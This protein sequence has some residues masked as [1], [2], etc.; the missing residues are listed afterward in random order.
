MKRTSTL[1]VLVISALALVGV[2]AVP[3][4]SAAKFVAENGHINIASSSAT[5]QIAFNG[6]TYECSG[7]IVEGSAEGQQVSGG[8]YASSSL[9]SSSIGKPNCV[10]SSMNWNGCQLTFHAPTGGTVQGTVDIGP[11]GCGPVVFK[12]GS[13]ERTISAQS[14][15][16]ATYESAG[17][18]T[19]RTVK[20]A[21]LTSTL[22]YT[23]GEGC[24]TKGSF[25]NGAWSA[26]L[27]LGAT[28][29]N[30][31][32][33]GLRVAVLPVGVYVAGAQPRF[34][35]EE[36][37]TDLVGQISKEHIFTLKEGVGSF[38]LNCGSASLNSALA[39]ASTSLDVG[40]GYTSCAK[41]LSQPVKV[42]MNSCSY[43]FQVV[44]ASPYSGT[45]KVGCTVPGDAIEFVVAPE[46]PLCIY[47]LPAQT[48]GTA[49]YTTVDSL[50]ERR[51]SAEVTGTG[52]T[53]N[54]TYNG[55][56]CPVGSTTGGFS[57]GF[58]LGGVE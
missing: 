19:G 12:Q 39:S 34:E 47:Q 50:N 10:S 6:P 16:G 32:A 58:S 3:S 25:S 42:N 51:I 27:T 48:L 15:I 36:Y 33:V 37:S 11:P 40:A 7:P 35:A 52:L 21:I 24:G 31:K 45:A 28:D 2:I 38:S 18:G 20:V 13:C 43:L 46:K 26:K 30:G 29:S 17:T 22:K 9:S 23:N 56:V 44:S 57:G 14:G 1:G 4:A 41:F 54:R 53:Y 49:T 5:Q 55:F 8:D